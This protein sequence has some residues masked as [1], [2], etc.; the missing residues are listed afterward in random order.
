[1][2]GII[3]NG[4]GLSP[5]YQEFTIG[6]N[7]V[8]YVRARIVTLQV[9]DDELDAVLWG[10]KNYERHISNQQ[11]ERNRNGRDEA[12]SHPEEVLR[13]EGGPG[14]HGVHAGAPCPEGGPGGLQGDGHPG[15]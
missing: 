8:S 5:N 7:L 10:I 4:Y 13:V 9:S 11:I 1:M 2:A 14:Q 3:F 15:R 12:R 6:A